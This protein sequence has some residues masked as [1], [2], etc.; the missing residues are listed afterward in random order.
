MAEGLFRRDHAGLVALRAKAM[1]AVVA[2]EITKTQFRLLKASTRLTPRKW[3]E[4][5]EEM[6]EDEIAAGFRAGGDW[7]PEDWAKL[8]NEIFA[9]LIENLPTLLAMCA[10]V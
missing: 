7:T 9:A 1:E 8:I 5:L 10:A 2:G 4:E 6:R 3:V